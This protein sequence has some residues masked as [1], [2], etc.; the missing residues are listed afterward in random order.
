MSLKYTTMEEGIKYEQ[1]SDIV[2]KPAIPN[3]K[4]VDRCFNTSQFTYRPY[5][6]IGPLPPVS[7]I[8]SFDPVVLKITDSILQSFFGMFVT[9]HFLFFPFPAE[10]S[11]DGVQTLLVNCV[12]SNC[13]DVLNQFT[14]KLLV[15]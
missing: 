1:N 8:S 6:W 14:C 3:N 12:P 10:K 11:H 13:V 9:N 5:A 2:I 7:D 15:S 4:N